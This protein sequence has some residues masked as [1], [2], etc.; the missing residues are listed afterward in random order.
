MTSV[1][2]NNIA[3]NVNVSSSASNAASV[4]FGRKQKSNDVG[5]EFGI[6]IDEKNQDKVQCTCVKR[7]ANSINPDFSIYVNTMKQQS[8]NDIILKEMT[9]ATQRYMAK[10]VYQ[11][12]I[13]FNAIDNACFLQMVEVIGRFGPS[14][15]PPSQW[16][17]RE[18][19][20]KKEF[21]TTKEA[22]KKQEQSWKVDACSIMTDT[23]TDMKRKSFMNLC[24]NC[25]EDTI[26]LSST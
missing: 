9:H 21:E 2:D 6:L 24:V 10:W 7:F 8:F 11:A 17:L 4:P 20:L 16:Q 1:L 13:P 25:K 22:L 26:F 3:D 18:P 12:V 23:W 19:L 15:K 5:W 14:F